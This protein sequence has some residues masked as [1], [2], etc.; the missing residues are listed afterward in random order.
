MVAVFLDAEGAMLVPDSCELA[1][2]DF[3]FA[4]LGDELCRWGT[5]DVPLEGA[6]R[7]AHGYGADN[8]Y[9][10]DWRCRVGFVR[11]PLPGL[12]RRFRSTG[13]LARR[14]PA[15]RLLGGRG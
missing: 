8:I 13:G 1:V 4:G 15:C 9:R 11:R 7:R 10:I 3:E 12:L 5:I 6:T 14:A 2:F